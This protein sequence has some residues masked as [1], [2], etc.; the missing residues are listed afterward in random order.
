[1]LLKL[2]CYIHF[3]YSLKVGSPLPYSETIMSD[4]EKEDDSLLASNSSHR[5]SRHNNIKHVNLLLI[6]H[7][8]H[9]RQPVIITFLVMK[10]LL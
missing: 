6:Y 8:L 10:S 2:F 4:K 3:S 7:R 9:Q 5:C 1:M